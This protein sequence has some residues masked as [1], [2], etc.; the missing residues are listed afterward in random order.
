VGTLSAL[1]SAFAAT[2]DDLIEICRATL[3][4]A[5]GSGLN[6]MEFARA[7]E[8][9]IF[10]MVLAGL[11]AAALI[12][13]VLLVRRGRRLAV[14]ALLP[15]LGI[16]RASIARHGAVALAV[17][18]IPFFL[19]ALAEPRSAFAR[20]ETSH[21]GR[22]IAILLDA[23][24][25][26]LQSL[27]ASRLAKGAPNDAA[28][29]TTVGA[30][31]YFVELRRKGE[32]RDLMSLV[33]FGDEAYVITPFTSDHDN[34]LLSMALIGDWTE[35]MNF[36]EQGTVIARAIDQGVGL[37]KAFDFLDAAGNVMVIFS[38]GMDAEVLQDGRTTFDVLREARRAE[39]PVYFIRVGRPDAP[40]GVVPDA[41]WEAA[42]ART[43]GRFYSAADEGTIVRAMREIDRQSAGR[44]EMREYTTQVPRYAPFALAAVVLWT[45]ALALRLAT[46][47]FT[48]FP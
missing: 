39:V 33:E 37:F 23:S 2:L 36:P 24:S 16:S 1:A 47:W 31:R 25:S 26:M 32:Y 22:R 29:F 5:S 48:T 17:L 14:P 38:D 44:I 21:P 46:P 8:A 40:Q 30:A 4:S 13:R 45:F 41:A 18:G 3:S 6:A 42:V 7:D 27:P 15:A 20:Q 43:G 34:I 11:I 28:F 19:L 10:V 9:R 35:F 12:V